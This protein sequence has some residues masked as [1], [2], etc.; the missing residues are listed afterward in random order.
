[1]IKNKINNYN[2]NSNNYYIYIY[3][4]QINYIYSLNKNKILFSYIFLKELI[5]MRGY[6]T[7]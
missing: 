4:L 1:M 5:E 2:M 7:I 3:M 6:G